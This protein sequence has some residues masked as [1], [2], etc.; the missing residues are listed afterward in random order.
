MKLAGF[1]VLQS[2]IEFVAIR[3]SGP[4]GQHVNKV[5]SAVHLRFDIMASS[6]PQSCKELLLDSSDQR[7]SSD[8]VIVI[9]AKKFRSQDKNKTDAIARLDEL[10]RGATAT[11]AVRKATRPT[12]ASK[13]RRIQDKKARSRTKNLRGSKNIMDS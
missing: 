1:E 6:L 8:G 9:K 7:I 3:A 12:L 11:Q 5:S 2:D 10:I 4:G 13:K